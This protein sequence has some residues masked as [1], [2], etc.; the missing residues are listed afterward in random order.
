MT[1]CW[2]KEPEKRLTFTEIYKRL[3]G[4]YDFSVNLPT[5]PQK[6]KEIHAYTTPPSLKQE[7]NEKGKTDRKNLVIFCH[8]LFGKSSRFFNLHFD[9]LIYFKILHNELIGSVTDQV[10]VNILN[11]LENGK[12]LL[13]CFLSYSRYETN[14]I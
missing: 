3:D 6:G 2:Y 10:P 5:I 4:D 8:D 7:S 1:R 13:M 11:N 14:T 9:A 12:N